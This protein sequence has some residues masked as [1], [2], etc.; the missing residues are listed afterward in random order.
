MSMDDGDTREHP[1]ESFLLI[2]YEW[3][4][5]IRDD[6]RDELRSFARQ[7]MAYDAEAGFTMIRDL[8]SPPSNPSGAPR[9]LVARLTSESDYH[10]GGQLAAY[11]AVS[12]VD[13]QGVGQAVLVVAPHLRSRGIATLL[14]EKLSRESPTADWFGTGLKGLRARA[15]GSHPAASRLARRFGF[16]VV[17]ETWLLLRM[18]RGAGRQVPAEESRSVDVDERVMGATVLAGVPVPS[19]AIVPAHGRRLFERTYRLQGDSAGGQ[20]S[21]RQSVSEEGVPDRMAWM[22]Y[23][24]AASGMRVDD[25]EALITRATRDLG[26]AGARLVMA[27]VDPSA[28]AIVRASRR[29]YF[30]H[31]QSNLVF[32]VQLPHNR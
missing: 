15:D 32:A 29:T 30:Q 17:R 23:S 10:S 6:L 25:I 12:D 21:T 14:V 18:I 4:A 1:G 9:H 24:P 27:E 13:E 19:S 8:E 28:E 16:P 2:E 22:S 3:F 31:D 20:L 26:A 5:E 7:A 11:L